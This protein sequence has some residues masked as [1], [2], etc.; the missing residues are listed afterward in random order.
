MQF[1]DS[2][3]I[4]QDYSNSIKAMKTPVSSLF[5]SSYTP[6]KTTLILRLF[7]S[8]VVDFKDALSVSHLEVSIYSLSPEERRFLPEIRKT[9]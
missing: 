6:K 9:P 5:V 1:L 7:F 3:N 4:L 8:V 2:F